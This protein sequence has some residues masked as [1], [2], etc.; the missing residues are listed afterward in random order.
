MLTGMTASP[1]RRMRAYAYTLVTTVIVL[2][3]ALA[4]W[5]AERFISER[6]AR[7]QRR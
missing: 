4:E 1:G 6:R 5:G 7:R 3:F 2:I